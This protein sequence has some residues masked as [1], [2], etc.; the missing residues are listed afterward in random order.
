MIVDACAW[1]GTWGTFALPGRVD[2]VLADLAGV[3]VDLVLLSPL[4]GVWAHDAHRANESVYAAA[5]DRDQ[6]RPVPVLD[7]T[8]PTWPEA[9]AAAV[10]ARAPAV[11]WLPAY[12]GFDLDDR[13]AADCA[14]ALAAAGVAL[15]VQTRLED[16]RR[17]HP[18]AVVPDV[19]A[20]A[21]VELSG[22]HPD[23]DVAIGGAPWKPLL[24][25]A[26]AIRARPRL[27]ADLSQVDGL[28]SAVRLV[29]A[30]LS[31]RLLFA[32]HAPFFVPLAGLAR[33]VVDLGQAE[34]AAILGGNAGRAFRLERG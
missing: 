27:W 1:T 23:L 26:D 32:T 21:V 9:L 29:G 13:R 30:G 11:R 3:G 5:R 20:A 16:P 19:S 10:A 12:S 4:G 8:L 22:R 24:D 15:W 33:V 7:P 2:E 17:Q 25:L 31:E 18:R 34:A 6:V 14:G 28:D